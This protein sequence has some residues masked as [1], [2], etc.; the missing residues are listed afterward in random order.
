MF[1]GIQPLPIDVVHR[2]TAGE[3]IDSLAAAVRELIENALDAGATRIAIAL[4]PQA[5]RIRVADNG[6]GM[7]LA[8]LRQAAAPHTTSRIRCEE[9]LRKVT[10]LG[11]RG[12]ALHSL[13][14]LAE[15]EICSRPNWASEGWRAVYSTQ[16][17]VIR[18]ETV[19]IAPGT[20]VTVSHLFSMWPARR[21]SLPT[22][23]Q[24]MRLVQ[25][26]I[27]QSA[28]CHPS[29]TWQAQQNDS[30]WFVIAPAETAKATLPQV[31][32]SVQLMDLEGL[33]IE[34]GA[35]Y[36]DVL[37]NP[38]MKGVGG[39]S[40]KEIACP[41]DV[42]P[43]RANQIEL[44]VGLPDR[45]HRHRP[46]WIRI[47][48][49]GRCVKISNDDTR[50]PELEQTILDAFRQTLPRN[51]YPICFVHL[52]IAPE[53]VDW[54]R[55]PAKTEIYLHNLNYWREQVAQAIQQVFQIGSRDSNTIDQPKQVTKLLKAAEVNGFYNLGR[56]IQTN[57]LFGPDAEEIGLSQLR[58]VAQIHRTYILAEH[59]AGLWLV[60]QH[61][62]HERVLYEQLSDHW[63]LVPL[64][65][66]TI[67][68]HLS[69][70]QVEQL[71]RL[72]IEIEL[73]GHEL[74]AVRSAPKP[75]AQ[76]EDC[77]DALQELSLGGDL[78]TAQVATACRSAIRNGVPLNLEAMQ[79]LLN[80]WQKTRHPRTCPHGRPIYLPLDESDL[81]RFFRRNWVIGKSHGI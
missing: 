40:P 20:V 22:P 24:Q 70:S 26:I 46:D 30:P 56:S 81:A 45:C 50:L 32:P 55:H 62:A 74:W 63:Q 7:G 1:S 9:D 57:Q 3:V 8:D 43:L 80:Q 65:P 69:P 6:C 77:P 66:P 41:K 23:K 36:V 12:E 27:Q 78:R 4:W 60:E 53:Q 31:L 5:W 17:K 58:A 21:Q 67:L 47:A 11:F 79:S 54:N 75:L 42:S 72:G 29:V 10:S 14:Q 73:F 48:V 16:G 28:L 59:P 61:I 49:N 2:I 64:E 68:N 15:L 18:P 33:K 71:Q 19:A 35:P 39:A 38:D 76:R 13:A 37:A 44:V 52:H 34:A 25:T 51:R